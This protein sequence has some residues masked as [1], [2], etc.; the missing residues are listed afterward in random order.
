MSLAHPGTL[1]GALVTLEPLAAEHHDG[2]VDAV[3][4]GELW[5]LWYTLVPR[6]EG[7]AAEIERRLA[8]Q[9]RGAMIPFT[10]RR[11]DTG[12]IIGMTTFMNIE[13]ET[14]RVEIGSTWNA[15]SAQGSGTNPESKLLLLGH[16]FDVWGCT[17]V[18]FRTDFHNHQSRAAIARLGAK[19][20]GVLRAHR[21]GEG[22]LRDTVVF[23]ITQ[24]EWPGVRLGLQHRLARHQG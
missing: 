4:D 10:T 13:A 22:Y 2:L 3:R 8:L 14:P 12:Q 5:D 17:A 9:E 16:A 11:T 21:Q 15:Q 18:E 1:S 7:M 24:P 23:S 19:Q 20:D 6:P